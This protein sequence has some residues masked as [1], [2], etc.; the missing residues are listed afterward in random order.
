MQW[1]S[2]GKG[3]RGVAGRGGRAGE[4]DG[5]TERRRKSSRRR[6][7]EAASSAREAARGSAARTPEVGSARPGENAR[8]GPGNPVSLVPKQRGN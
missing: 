3:R 7:G 6:D 1:R 4:A 5:E 2:D 8:I